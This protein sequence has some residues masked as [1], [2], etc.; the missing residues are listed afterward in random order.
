MDL[1]ELQQRWKAYD[2]KLDQSLRLNF[3][4]L[5]ATT[6]ARA[7]GSLRRLTWWLGFE[8]LAL[9]PLTG[10]LAD[11]L[12][13]HLAAPRFVALGALLLACTVG[14]TIAAL[15]QLIAI[16]RLDV[17]QP[18]VQLQRRLERLGV[19]RIRATV[20]AVVLGPLVWV[21]VL[22]VFAEGVLGVDLTRVLSQA[23][24]VANV[25]LGVVVVAAALWVARRYA[26][27]VMGWPV[28]RR[29]LRD[30]AGHSINDA[31]RFLDELQQLEPPR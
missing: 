2:R 14:L 20:A 24:I 1:D 7:T 26:N 10:W 12:R 13:G 29:L 21:P 22:L 4:A 18:V 31:L 5:R 27:R 11:F 19:E 16:A 8:L 9:V 23:W 6:L 17:S 28:L 30:L 3:E 25:A 15:R